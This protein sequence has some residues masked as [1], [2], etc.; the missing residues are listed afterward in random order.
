MYKYITMHS[1]DLEVEV[2]SYYSIWSR[3][4]ADQAKNQL[5]AMVN[6]KIENVKYISCIFRKF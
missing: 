4:L 1:Y 3:S 6:L 2:V 5:Y